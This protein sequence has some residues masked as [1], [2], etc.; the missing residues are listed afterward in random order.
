[1]HELSVATS[2]VELVH[3]ECEPRGAT[4]VGT[5][6]LRV[7]EAAGILVD[8]LTYCY[9]LVAEQDPLLRASELVVEMVPHRAACEPCGRDFAVAD[10]IARCPACGEWSRT[11]VSGTE[12]QILDVEYETETCPA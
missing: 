5:V 1:M 8:S 6:R 12:L 2:L 7:G 10:S 9:R 11:I 3:E 4:S